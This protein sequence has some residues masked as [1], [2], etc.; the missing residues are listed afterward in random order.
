MAW[1]PAPVPADEPLRQAALR[2]LGWF[3]AH[4]D[5]LSEAVPVG[6]LRALADAARRLCGCPVG[7]VSLVDTDQ[8][9]Q[10]GVEG[11]V[12]SAAEGAGTDAPV[13]RWH[14]SPRAQAICAHAVAANTFLQ[15]PDVLDDARFAGAIAHAASEGWRFYAAMPLRVAGHPVGTL[16]V[17]APRPHRLSP[18]Q[19]QQLEQ[20]AHAAEALLAA[21]H[22]REALAREAARL[23]DLARASGDWLWELDAQ[24][25]HR[26]LSEDF[27]RLAGVP[28]SSLIGQ[29]IADEPCVDPVGEPLG[30]GLGLH[31]RLAAQPPQP[32]TRVV[33]RLLTPRGPLYVSRSAVPVFDAQGRLEAW[34]GSARDVT[35]Q[36]VATRRTQARDRRLHTLLA[37]L[38]GAA[39][40][41][42]LRANGSQ[43]HFLYVN[44]GLRE[45]LG[46]NPEEGPGSVLPLWQRVAKADRRALAQALRAA[47]RQGRPMHVELQFLRADG[48]WRWLETRA[49][50]EPQPDGRVVLH[51]FTWDVSDRRRAQDALRQHESLRLAH[52]GAERASRAKS[53]FLSRV[54]HELRTPL[55]AILGFTDLMALDSRQPLGDTQRRRLEGVRQAGQGLL[56]LVDDVLDV[57]RIEQGQL[58]L[59]HD[60]VPLAALLRAA[61]EAVEPLA[62]SHGVSLSALEPGPACARGDAAAMQQ[63]LVNLLS[64][65]IKY[66]RPGGAVRVSCETASDGHWSV[67]VDDEGPGLRPDQLAQLFQPFNRLGAERRRIGGTGLGLVIARALARAMG[68]DVM[69]TSTPGQGSRFTMRLAPAAPAESGGGASGAAQ[70]AGPSTPAATGREVLYIEDEP[71]NVLLMEEV[72]RTQPGWTLHVARDGETGVALARQLQPQL[73]LID[74][75]LP[76]MNGL[77]VLRRLRADGRT[78]GLL[79]VALSADA[80]GEQISAARA[81][82]FDD[83]WT[84]PIDLTRLLDDVRRIIE[85]RAGDA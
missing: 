13:P 48:Q 75:N 17:A 2:D 27:E 40:Q 63:V 52:E 64:N 83:Y 65:A 73:V 42:R 33:T 49:T 41:L 19:R 1:R 68:G 7:L 47:L 57:S 56:A 69:A 54:S 23:G 16:A 9:W 81:A 25:R 50:A 22:A 46:A 18:A 78:A 28:A 82:G 31:A 15:V 67:H 43:P 6:A 24:G 70:A 80:M 20:L 61:G 84:K 14:V 72:F 74:M 37:Q 71:L 58:R 30:P 62:R 10:V 36:V 35:A 55:N 11:G 51:G 3:S 53:E 44:D 4:T 59:R 26:W 77:E 8:A 60:P 39:F 5:G 32:L 38:P 76:D 34:R 29:V 12:D 45:L 66:N 79:C 85:R 21:Q